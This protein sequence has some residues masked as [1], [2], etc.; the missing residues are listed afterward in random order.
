MPED[1]LTGGYKMGLG[2]QV[3]KDVL[4]TYLRGHVWVSSPK[5]K[6][7]KQ[8]DMTL[9]FSLLTM[10]SCSLIR[11]YVYMCMLNDGLKNR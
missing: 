11:Y 6:Q 4:L 1:P 8:L 10:F 3:S 5:T 7:Y 9:Y 2:S